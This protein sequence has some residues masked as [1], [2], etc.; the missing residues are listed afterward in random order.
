MSLRKSLLDIDL[1]AVSPK[2]KSF[3]REEVKKVGVEGVVVGLSGG[4]DSS[5]VTYLCAEALGPENV[6]GFIMPD[7][8]VT[9]H[10][11]IQDAKLVAEKLGIDYK[12]VD[13]ASIYD[14]VAKSHPLFNPQVQVANGNL[15]ARIRMVLLYYT[16][17]MLNRLVVGSGDKSELLIGY[18]TKYGDGGVDILPIGD[19]YKTQVR[20][21]ASHLGVPAHIASKP[22]S[23]RLWTGQLAEEELGIKYDTIDPILHGLVDLK[24]SREEVAKEL[25]VPLDAVN[26]VQD[27]IK[28]TEH[29]RQLPPIAKI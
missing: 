29:K 5:T 24:M 2:L 3:I 16:S 20:A 17:N 28:R 8:K 14:S 10:G 21:L 18:Y 9:P 4:V 12:I 11:D 23:P 19:L 13:I 15:R 7:P 26:K 6:L 25:G 22:S 27:M 1:P